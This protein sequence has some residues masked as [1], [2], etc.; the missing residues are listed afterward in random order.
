[1]V[2]E[3]TFLILLLS[4]ADYLY[5]VCYMFILHLLALLP[6]KLEDLGLGIKFRNDTH[7][8]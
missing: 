3:K 5:V 6:T 4:N 7:S 1:M 2:E 8:N